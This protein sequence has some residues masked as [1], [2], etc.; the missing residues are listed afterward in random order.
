[1]L[2]KVTQSEIIPFSSHNNFGMEEQKSCLS[3]SIK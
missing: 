1:M 3:K 2:K